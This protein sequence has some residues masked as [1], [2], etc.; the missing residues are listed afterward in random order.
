[1]V[2][3]TIQTANSPMHEYV[4]TPGNTAKLGTAHSNIQ[5]AQSCPSQRTTES[6]H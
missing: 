5:A 1:M 2:G 6:V 4:R 3:K